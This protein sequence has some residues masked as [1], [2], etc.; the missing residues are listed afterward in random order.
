MLLQWSGNLQRDMLK[1]ITDIVREQARIAVQGVVNTVTPQVTAAMQKELA[2]A[3]GEP[4]GVAACGEWHRPSCL[5]LALG[6]EGAVLRVMN[7]YQYDSKRLHQSCAF[8]SAR[9]GH[10]LLCG[11]TS[12]Q[13]QWQRGFHLPAAALQALL[14]SHLA[15]VIALAISEFWCSL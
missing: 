9:R 5:L 13:R 14:W 3:A 15:C 12:S 11:P 8:L 7:M 6:S 4:D 1:A 10:V 2:G